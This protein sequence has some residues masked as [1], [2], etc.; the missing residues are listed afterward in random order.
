MPL[1]TIRNLSSLMLLLAVLGFAVGC[2]SRPEPSRSVRLAVLD[3]KVLYDVD[4]KGTLVEEGWWFSSRDRFL[5]SNMGIQ[6]GEA[7]AHQFDKLPG[8]EVYSRDDQSIYLSLKERQIDRNYPNLTPAQRKQL[9]LE[10]DPLDYGKSLGMDFVMTS[11]VRKSATVI[12][13]TFSW[14]YSHLDTTVQLWDVASGQMVWT[15]S[16]EDSDAFDSQLAM[17]EECARELSRRVTRDDAFVL[18]PAS[19]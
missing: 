4:P 18:Y 16:W 3:G 1:K 12:N 15:R 17:A 14:W 7:L 2:A 9:L 11:E 6:L 19:R 10:Q 13:R 5:S 8:V